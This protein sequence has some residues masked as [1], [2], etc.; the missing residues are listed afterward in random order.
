MSMG[1]AKT[2]VTSNYGVR[3]KNSC[4]ESVEHVVDTKETAVMSRQSQPYPH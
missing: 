2:A 1:G 3:I 4:F